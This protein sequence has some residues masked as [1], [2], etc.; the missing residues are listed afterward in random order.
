MGIEDEL[1]KAA[2]QAKKAVTGSD[3]DKQQKQQQ[4]E[5]ADTS[6]SETDSE[7]GVVSDDEGR[8][9]SI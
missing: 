2:D 7:G 6:S 1:G 5:T 3:E 8:A 4:V 9:G